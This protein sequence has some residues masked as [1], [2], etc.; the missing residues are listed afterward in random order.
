VFNVCPRCGE[1]AEEKVIDPEG[2]F[3]ICPRCGYA[4]RFVR[5][6]LFLL[7]GASGTGKSTICMELVGRASDHVV[8]ES[9][10]LWMPEFATPED[11]Y[12]RYRNLWLRVAKNVH[13]AGRPVV[14][15]GTA[16]PEQFEACPEARYFAGIHT[17]AL[18]CTDDVLVQRLTDRPAWR[19]SATPEFIQRMLNF[20]RWL[21][22]NAALST[23]PIALLDTSGLSIR[24]SVERVQQWLSAS[25]EHRS[26]AI[27][28]AA[29]IWGTQ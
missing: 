3:A 26:C 17:L 4:H 6:P 24:Q 19:Q 10:I 7:S 16:V 1:Y 15:C 27:P 11:D 22:A 23:P 5:L 18:V 12:R 14:L 25:A 29:S 21:K 9:D 28:P 2:P 13:Q 20:N 8:M